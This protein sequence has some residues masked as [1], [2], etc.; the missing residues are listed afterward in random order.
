MTSTGPHPHIVFSGGGTGGHLFPGLAVAQRLTGDVPQVQIT[1][2]GSG[3]RFERRQVAA[4]G[5]EYLPLPCHPLPRTLRDVFPFVTDN[6][7][8]YREA[9]RF[10]DGRRVSAVVG[11][12]GY[13]SVP[14]ARAAIHSGVPLVLLEQNA[15]P[16]R[17]TRWLAPAAALVC[18]AFAEASQSLGSRCAA[19]VTG[20]PIRPHFTRR[21]PAAE[22]RP[23]NGR[24]SA[25]GPNTPPSPV[26]DS[27]RSN[28][29]N[30]SKV[31]LVVGGTAGAQS[32]NEN[33]PGALYK[34]GAALRGWKIAH[35]SGSAELEAT[36]ERYQ[37][38]GLK[39][40]VVPF[41]A[42][43]P[44][45]LDQTDLVICRAGGTTLAELA[46]TGVP[47]ILLPYPFAADDHQ[48][49]NADVFSEAGACLTLDERELPGR[50]DDH[51]AGAVSLLT[52]NPAKRAA[53]AQAMRGLA[54]PDATWDVA[55]MVRQVAACNG[56]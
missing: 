54:L 27:N 8:G 5:F 15:V 21:P 38:L 35:Q 7:H 3:R 41:I 25:S 19:R 28:G 43:M 52:G 2:A 11:L 32:L 53:M 51:L 1:F 56:S 9:R 42:N 47:A 44:Q 39:A 31:L 29:D 26:D 50:I 13:A 22:A 36:R 49:K 6:L 14:M 48:R 55:T 23:A 37:K 12:G 24:R 34:V 45:V 33:V 16:G 18:T 40:T 10:L 17:A 20:N 30:R 4:A 46:A